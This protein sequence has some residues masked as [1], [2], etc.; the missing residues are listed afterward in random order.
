MEDIQ[1]GFPHGE[2]GFDAAVGRFEMLQMCLS[3]RPAR[4]TTGKSGR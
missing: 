4:W 1:N 3:T 2:D